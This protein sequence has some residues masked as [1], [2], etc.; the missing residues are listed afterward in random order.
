MK[1]IQKAADKMCPKA[2]EILGNIFYTGNRIP[3]DKEK[4]INYLKMATEE[5][6]GYTEHNI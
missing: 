3:I 1:Y 5:G 4:G 2:L 6:W